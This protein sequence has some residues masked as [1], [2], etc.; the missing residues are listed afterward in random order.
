MFMC[1][2]SD[3]F[4]GGFASGPLREGSAVARRYMSDPTTGGTE[5]LI[6]ADVLVKMVTVEAYVCSAVQKLSFDEKQTGATEPTPKW[7]N[8]D[9]LTHEQLLA[10]QCRDAAGPGFRR[11]DRHRRH[12]TADHPSRLFAGRFG[13]QRQR[14]R[15]CSPAQ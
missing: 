8:L 9:G 1:G 15:Q 4:S 10:P 6:W 5:D 12:A 3:P 11:P 13:G 14:F 2:M 7:L